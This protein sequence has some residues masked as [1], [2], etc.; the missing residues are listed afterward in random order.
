VTRIGIG[1]GHV[2]V[3]PSV[4]GPTGRQPAQ[5]GVR[6]TLEQDGRKGEFALEGPMTAEVVGEAIL[7]AKDE[8]VREADAVDDAAYLRRRGVRNLSAHDPSVG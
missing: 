4:S 1:G 7:Q 2:R 6:L 3:E 5:A 8:A